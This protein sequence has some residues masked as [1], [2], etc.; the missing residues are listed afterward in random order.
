MSRL[1]WLLGALGGAGVLYALS[2]TERGQAVASDALEEITVTAQ[3]I[4]SAVAKAVMPPGIRNNNPGNIEWIENPSQRWRGMISRNGRFGVFD[5]A[6][7]GIRAI[8]G[9]LRA[10]IRRGQ[11]LAEAIHEWAPPTEND[12]DSYLRHV[13]SLTGFAPS[14]KL[15][16]GMVPA[17]TGAIILHENGQ[18]PYDPAD[19][20]VW[21]NA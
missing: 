15:S 19:I 18:Q 14:L 11:T 6:A 21:V 20:A 8:G 12:T 4:G 2:R 5:S 9:E 16:A 1:Y 3:R 17:V 7:N 13:E 10:S